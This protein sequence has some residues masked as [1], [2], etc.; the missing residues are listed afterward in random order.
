MAVYGYPRLLHGEIVETGSAITVCV[1]ENLN[2]HDTADPNVL[3][4]TR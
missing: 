3:H 2:A 4:D 1:V